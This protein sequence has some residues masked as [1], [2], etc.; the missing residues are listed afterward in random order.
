VNLLA[1]TCRAVAESAAGAKGISQRSL[2]ATLQVSLG[3]ANQ[4]V[5]KAADAG[6]LD[7]GTLRLTPAG[8]GYLDTFA[9]DN[10][11][12]LAAGFGSR[13]VPLTFDTPKGLLTVHGEAMV[14][15]EIRQLREAGIEEIIVVVGY[16]KEQFEYLVDKYG[17][18][19]VFN[20]EYATKN[21]LASLYHVRQYLASSYILV[22]DNWLN[23]NPF[24]RWEPDSWLGGLYFEGPTSEWAVTFRSHGLVKKID[25]GGADTWALLG[26]AHFTREFSARYVPLLEKAYA[27]PGTE[28]WYWEHVLKENLADLPFSLLKQPEGQIH[29]FE[30]LAELR[31]FDHTYVEQTNSVIMERIADALSVAESQVD[32]IKP[33][34]NGLTNS[35]FYFTAAGSE[36]VY[37]RPQEG[38]NRWIDRGAEAATYEA[39]APLSIADELV[40]A[41]PATGQRIAR[42]FPGTRPLDASDPRE[43]ARAIGALRR[44]HAS[45]VRVDTRTDPAGALRRLRELGDNAIQFR[46]WDRVEAEVL[47]AAAP[48]RDVVPEPVLVHGDFTAAN[49]LVLPSGQVKIIDWELAGMGDPLAD[50]ATFAAEARMG[51]ERSVA[52]L[53][54][55][56]GRAASAGER[57]RFYAWT[58]LIAL[59][60][61]LW[62]EYR[63]AAGE[64]VGEYPLAMY[65]RAKDYSRLALA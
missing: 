63:Q 65:R 46:D 28:N 45:G 4:L 43:V 22:A 10:A 58:A 1:L 33:L 31:E 34:K 17:V 14:E 52:L 38:A 57:R 49:V 39:L 30:S 16:L 8:Q 7:P 60:N 25:V 40:W 44:V 64:L 27:T 51:P 36:Y 61:T 32:S 21:N 2:A 55:Y 26:P 41:D 62:A 5:K 48:L 59:V 19:L 9:V 12:V 50:I 13:F 29:E 42:Y 11:I 15:R 3:T 20:P 35:S 37:R 6:Y 24:H 23:D 56:L 54:H 53:A 18:R 47:R